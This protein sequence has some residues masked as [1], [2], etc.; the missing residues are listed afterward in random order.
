MESTRQLFESLKK[1]FDISRYTKLKEKLKRKSSIISKEDYFL[2]MD[3]FEG[4]ESLKNLESMGVENYFLRGHEMKLNIFGF[5]GI[6]WN[7]LDGNPIRTYRK[8]GV[9]IFDNPISGKVESWSNLDLAKYSK[10]VNG[11]SNGS[12]FIFHREELEYEVFNNGVGYLDKTTLGNRLFFVYDFGKPVG[13]LK[14]GLESGLVK[15]QADR[16]K[17]FKGYYTQIHGY[18]ISKQEFSRELSRLETKD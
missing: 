3:F 11:N 13:I 15:L 2:W 1:N 12:Q 14:N 4:K 16:M 10:H 7:R 5:D 18:P 17:K 9:L 6:L 8:K